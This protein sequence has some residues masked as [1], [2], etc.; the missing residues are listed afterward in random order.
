MFFFTTEALLRT[1][2]D[3]PNLIYDKLFRLPMQL[4]PL[5]CVLLTFVYNKTQQNKWVASVLAACSSYYYQTNRI[6]SNVVSIPHTPYH[7]TSLSSYSS[8]FLFVSDM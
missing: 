2:N 5:F 6:Y 1:K 4:F 8:L 3:Q 7:M